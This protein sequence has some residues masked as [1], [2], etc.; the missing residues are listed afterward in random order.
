[1]KYKD[2]QL[3]DIVDIYLEDK[4]IKRVVIIG[5]WEIEGW[6]YGVD[7]EGCFYNIEP[8]IEIKSIISNIDS[9]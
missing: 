2:I 8:T 3:G 4:S 6:L 1:M 7:K 9:L 5:C